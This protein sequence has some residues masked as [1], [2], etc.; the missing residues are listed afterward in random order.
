LNASF[1][2]SIRIEWEEAGD[3]LIYVA[4]SRWQS[5]DAD[6][7]L[8]VDQLVEPTILRLPLVD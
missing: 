4:A 7:K 6:G 5:F 8:L 2:L 3:D 1:L